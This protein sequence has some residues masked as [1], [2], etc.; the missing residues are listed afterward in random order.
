M[1]RM[2]PSRTSSGVG[3]SQMPW[4]RLMPETRSHSRVMRRIS[5]CANELS[6]FAMRMR[7]LWLERFYDGGAGGEVADGFDQH[8][9]ATLQ[10]GHRHLLVDVVAGI[11]LAG[12]PHSESDRVPDPLRIG[13]PARD[14]EGPPP[15]RGAPGA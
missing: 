15:A 1:A 12:E 6:R 14:G 3:R 5:D 4:P 2:A 11:G 9:E 8:V 13:A 10:I 7:G